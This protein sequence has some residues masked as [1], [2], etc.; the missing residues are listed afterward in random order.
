MPFAKLQKLRKIVNPQQLL[1]NRRAPF[2][3]MIK[4]R[5]EVKRQRQLEDFRKMNADGVVFEPDHKL[6][7]WK[8]SSAKNHQNKGKSFGGIRLRAVTQV[9]EPGYPTH[10]R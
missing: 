3:P 5:N 9:E 4:E 1:M 10:F 7:P 6:P 2:K 8:R